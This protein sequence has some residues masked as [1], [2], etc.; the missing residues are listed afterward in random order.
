MCRIFNCVHKETASAQ[1]YHL[2]V[3]CSQDKRHNDKK[4]GR[5]F[6]HRI[7][8][9]YGKNHPTFKFQEANLSEN[10]IIAFN[11]GRWTY[12]NLLKY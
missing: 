4:T 11:F 5:C 7:L 6:V 8:T 2:N 9:S 1:I 12:G 3:I 10:V